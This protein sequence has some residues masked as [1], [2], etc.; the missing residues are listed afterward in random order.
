[1]AKIQVESEV[2]VN[3]APVVVAET[4]GMGVDDGIVLATTLCLLAAVLFM[5]LA[6]KWH[7]QAGM[8][9]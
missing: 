4:G 9:A 5:A 2:E 7:Y 8:L 6:C 3:E 1:M